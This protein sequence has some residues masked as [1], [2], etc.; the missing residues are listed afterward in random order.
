MYVMIGRLSELYFLLAMYSLDYFNLNQNRS[1][2]IICCFF[3]CNVCVQRQAKKC[4]INVDN[5]MP[6]GLLGFIYLFEF[7]Y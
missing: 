1:N 7:I 4:K 6:H 3:L 2:V 5:Y